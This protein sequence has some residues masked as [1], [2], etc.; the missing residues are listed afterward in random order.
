MPESASDLPTCLS[1]SFCAAAWSA[2]PMLNAV[3]KYYIILAY[4]NKK[5][6]SILE[7]LFFNHLI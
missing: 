5:G 3:R 7:A 4:F 6:H 2:L 1:F